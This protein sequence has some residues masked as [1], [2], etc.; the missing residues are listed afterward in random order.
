[1]KSMPRY[2]V[3]LALGTGS[4]SFSHSVARTIGRSGHLHSFEFH[5]LRAAKA[6]FVRTVDRFKNL[7]TNSRLSK[8]FAENG[9]ADIVSLTHQNVC[10]DGFSLEDTV[11]AGVFI[12]ANGL[13]HS[14][15]RFSAI[16]LQSSLICQHP[17]RQFTMPKEPYE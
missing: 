17:G 9:I 10:K 16:S 14:S 1:M 6:R 2:L 5:E 12:N 8:E 13:Q 4:G 11:D 15:L 3:H 7:T